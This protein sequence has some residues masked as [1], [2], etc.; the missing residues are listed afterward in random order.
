M[1]VLLTSHVSGQNPTKK[2]TY[3]GGEMT[4]LAD[5]WTQDQ[6]DEKPWGNNVSVIYDTFFK[7]YVIVYSDSKGTRRTLTFEYSSGSGDNTIYM[8]DNFRFQITYV[9]QDYDKSY[10]FSFRQAPGDNPRAVFNISNLK[11]AI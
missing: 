11:K 5:Y 8:S 10:Y 9:Y 3:K 4:Y 1:F 7:S 2:V 6:S